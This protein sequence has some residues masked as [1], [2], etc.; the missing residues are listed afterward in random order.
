MAIE[1]VGRFNLQSFESTQTYVCIVRLICSVISLTSL[2][3]FSFLSQK[4]LRLLTLEAHT[5]Q[6]NKKERDEKGGVK[7]P[8]TQL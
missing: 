5:L 2:Y 7:F 4:V 8:H 1:E 3:I 6:Q